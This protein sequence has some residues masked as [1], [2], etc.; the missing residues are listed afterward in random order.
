MKT[1]AATV[2]PREFDILAD[3]PESFDH[4]VSGTYEECQRMALY[5]FVWGRIPKGEG[6]A[7]LWGR[8]FHKV[9]EVWLETGD[10][11]QVMAVIE[12]NIPE[13]TDD[14]YGRNQRKMQDAFVEWVKFNQ[15]N[16]LEVVSTEQVVTIL[17]DST[18]PYSESGCGLA[19]GGRMDRIVNWN[20]LV[21]PL[22]IKTTVMQA[23]DPIAEFR[24]D[25]QIGGYV[26]LAS[27]ILGK[28]CWGAIIEQVIANKSNLRVRRFPIPFAEDHIREWMETEKLRQAEFRAKVLQHPY[29]EIQWRQNFGRCWKPYPCHYRDVCLS[30][31]NYGFRLRWLRD[32]TDESRWDYNNPD[33]REPVNG[34][35]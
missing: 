33:A 12:T 2:D 20:S 9:V 29:D 22:D 19:Y 15:V 10:L 8:T 21:G 5:R 14:R 3:P 7:L 27:H 1:V 30:P 18:C 25:H 32:N 23:S 13:D 11:T 35:A 6:F 24:P 28:H 17:C 26:W 34:A 16:P 4:Q 31:R